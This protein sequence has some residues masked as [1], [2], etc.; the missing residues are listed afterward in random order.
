M[1]WKQFRQLVDK[2]LAKITGG[3]GLSDLSDVDIHAYYPGQDG[4]EYHWEAL[5]ADA[6]D[7]VLCENGFPGYGDDE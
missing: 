6:A 7:H 4:E 1:T 3:L 5:A 2:Q